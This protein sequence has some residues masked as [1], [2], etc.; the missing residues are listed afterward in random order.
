MFLPGNYLSTQTGGWFTPDTIADY[1]SIMSD[2]WWYDANF[3]PIF[4]DS[5]EGFTHSYSNIAGRSGFSSHGIKPVYDLVTYSVGNAAAEDDSYITKDVNGNMPTAMLKNGFLRFSIPQTHYY[6]GAGDVVTLNDGSSTFT[7]IIN[8]KITCS[9][10]AVHDGSGKMPVQ[11]STNLTVISIDKCF[12]SLFEAFGINGMSSFLGSKNLVTPVLSARVLCYEM[13]DDTG[14]V[15]AHTG[16]TLSKDNKIYIYAPC[17]IR[18]DCNKSQRHGDDETTGYTRFDSIE[19]AAD[20]VVDGLVFKK[21]GFGGN[22]IYIM[23]GGTVTCNIF[24]GA[25]AYGVNFIGDEID[26]AYVSS[27]YFNGNAVGITCSIASALKCQLYNN[28]FYDCGHSIFFDSTIV[29]I[30][31]NLMQG[32][33]Q[34]LMDG[35]AGLTSVSNCIT[36]DGSCA[37]ATDSYPN[38]IIQFEDTANSNLQAKYVE[39]ATVKNG[40]VVVLPNPVDIAGN[41]FDNTYCIGAYH[42]IRT[43]IFAIGPT[44]DD[45][46]SGTPSFSITDGLLTFTEGQVSDLLCAGCVVTSA[47][48]PVVL[49]KKISDTEWEVMNPDGT[50]LSGDEL[51][52]VV[53]S[54]NF[55]HGNLYEATNSFDLYNPISDDLKI[56]VN[57]SAGASNQCVTIG[58]NTDQTRNITIQAFRRHNGVWDDNLFI[59][60]G[61][62]ALEKS[63]RITAPY[64]V[65]DG[66]QLR[67]GQYGIYAE[68][69]GLVAQN[70]IIRDCGINGITFD[71]NDG[72][73]SNS[74]VNN[75][76]YDC[77]GIG[78]EFKENI[79]KPTIAQF[80]DL[81]VRAIEYGH[82]NAEYEVCMNGQSP[83]V[84]PVIMWL[85]E[86]VEITYDDDIYSSLSAII[87]SAKV[88]GEPWAT[89]SYLSN[90]VPADFDKKLS[91]A[92]DFI[93]GDYGFENNY[94][95][96]YNNTII[97]CHHG[98]V[99]ESKPINRYY[100]RSS[101]K[102]NIV[103]QCSGGAYIN[104]SPRSP[105]ITADCCIS[106]DD[107]LNKFIGYSNYSMYEIENAF[108]INLYESLRTNS[109]EM[110]ADP[111]FSFDYDSTGYT[112]RNNG[113]LSYKPLRYGNEAHFSIGDNTDD[114]LDGSFDIMISGGI[115]SLIGD[116]IGTKIGVGDKISCAAGPF[117]I[118]EK[119]ND[120]TWLVVKADGSLADDTATQSVD[121]IKRTFNSTL[122]INGAT[123]NDLST[124]IGF[125]NLVLN[126]TK[127][128]LWFYGDNEFVEQVSIGN[129]WTTDE[130]YT[131]TLITPYNTKTQCITRQR[132]NG[133]HN[134]VVFN[135]SDEG[136][137]FDLA[138]A[139]IYMEGFAINQINDVD[140]AVKV[141]GYSGCVIKCNVVKGGNT[142][143][144]LGA[145]NMAIS[146]IVHDQA[147]SG[148]ELNNSKSYNNTCVNNGDYAFNSL[149]AGD[150]IINCVGEGALIANFNGLGQ[151]INCYGP[152]LS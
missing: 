45:L 74:V 56:I 30:K 62:D 1:L 119:G 105:H 86:R 120:N 77:A 37:G 6:F 52:Y 139:N 13:G 55:S 48:D 29:E 12:N 24:T 68:A 92:D 81:V 89:L 59:H 130:E 54:I 38:T 106:D 70:N 33:T 5:E 104:H 125:T 73:N 93:R 84:Y 17:N 19:I 82:K 101:L 114:L 67:G 147:L 61:E 42:D 141:N 25:W 138:N 72:E 132:H 31:N 151:F 23:N 22:A 26:K 117:Y 36:S 32:G 144:V 113:F 102:N 124:L 78:I 142:G 76:I 131:I 128:K 126:E 118:A 40:A 65:I 4:S 11:Y 108:Y 112:R 135:Y 53:T 111:N 28:S 143:I 14:P 20:I 58:G 95:N 150:E 100:N 2:G 146:N 47:I 127:I 90:S 148:I 43:V 21:V 66:L 63:I 18:T 71:S 39:M 8:Y 79:G 80:G 123:P 3:Q 109:L 51:S 107:S 145:G 57:C 35:G 44:A 69:V 122:S 98:I 99:V 60:Y 41:I 96:I 10:W 94:L 110:V 115:A 137:V 50:P 87:D 15:D 134:G 152:V 85:P 129:D 16:W 64:T 49:R 88:Y 140:A 7:V 34:C 103:V 136:V 121:W 149:H 133:I 46:K 83:S 9:I 116:G 97:R 91:G 75:L 27:N